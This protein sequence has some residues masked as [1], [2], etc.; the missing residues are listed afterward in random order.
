MT[1]PPPCVDCYGSAGIP[2]IHQIPSAAELLGIAFIIAG[3]AIH[4]EAR[5]A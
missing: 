1:K 4:R 2:L 3:V 5:P